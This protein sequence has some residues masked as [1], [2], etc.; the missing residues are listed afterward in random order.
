MAPP[1][2][3]GEQTMLFSLANVATWTYT[4]YN[5]IILYAALRSIPTELYE[6]AAVDGA[7]PVSTAWHIKLPLLRPALLL[8]TI[9]SVIGSFQLFG[10]PRIFYALAPDVIGKVVH[11]EPLRLQPGVR[12]SAPE[13]R[14]R[15]VVHARGSRLR[16]VV[17]RHVHVPAAGG[18]TMSAVPAVTTD[19]PLATDG[20][21][22]PRRDATGLPAADKGFV[23]PTLFMLAFLVYFLMPLWWLLVSSTK[24][25]DDLFSS[26][27]LWFS[28]FN[29]ADN[30][31]ETFSKD[32]GIYW[33]W[34]RNTLVY[35]FV[36]A[37]G[38][39][40]LA[41]MGGYGFAKFAFRGKEACCSGSCWER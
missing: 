17:R 41:A 2:F 26:F 34:L 11:A 31:S 32:G 20:H 29:F 3:L 8:C 4:G 33:D 30:I 25:I 18:E 10:E 14:G 21:E 15:P 38:A 37:I 22:G 27:G 7:G 1:N 6:A 19:A 9:F 5:M 24:S 35:S 12:R 39:A 13:L 36:S 40:L 16:G 23:F 28:H